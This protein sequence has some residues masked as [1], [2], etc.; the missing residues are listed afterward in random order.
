MK[1]EIL[2]TGCARCHKLEEVTR[3]AVKD[4]GVAVELTKVEDIKKIM[5]YGVMT[6]PAL[7]IDSVVKVAGKIPTK[8]E[9]IKLISGE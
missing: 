9:I 3:E 4:S 6:L 1:I 2:G 5:G 7:V 8:E